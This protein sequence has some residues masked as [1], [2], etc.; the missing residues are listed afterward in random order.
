MKILTVL[1]V[2]AL[3]L[4]FAEDPG[5]ISEDHSN[6]NNDQAFQNNAQKSSKLKIVKVEPTVLFKNEQDGLLQAVDMTVNNPGQ[7]VDGKLKVRFRSLKEVSLDIGTIKP[8][9]DKYRFFVPDVSVIKSVEFV[10]LT[11]NTTQ[12]RLSMTWTPRKHWEICMIPISHHDLGYT[13]T[14]ERVLQQYCGIY[15]NVIQFCEETENYP[16]EAKFRYSVEESWS[17][18]YFIENSDKETLAKLSKYMK[19]GR[20]EVHGFIR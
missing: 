11:G 4:A 12:D 19:E 20:I 14:I 8:G 13:N 5:T 3:N 10:L 7:A 2:M 17:L 18:Q 9:E 15:H 16:D 6:I 1:I